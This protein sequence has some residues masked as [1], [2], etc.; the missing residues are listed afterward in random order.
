MVYTTHADQIDHFKYFFSTK[1]LHSLHQDTGDE[2]SNLII[3]IMT[4]LHVKL[5]G[6]FETVIR[7]GLKVQHVYL[8]DSGE[9]NVID[10]TGLFILAKL[11]P[12]SFFGELHC[13]TAA[14]SNFNFET[15]VLKESDR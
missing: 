1:E 4:H 13:T 11:P 15:G 12:G 2:A 10:S 14:A 6:S 8:I 5:F 7:A 3:D 9:V